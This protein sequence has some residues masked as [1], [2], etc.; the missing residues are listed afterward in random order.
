MTWAA[1]C[2]SAPIPA[3]SQADTLAYKAYGKTLHFGDGTATATNSTTIYKDDLRRK[4]MVFSGI[5]KNE[6]S[7]KSPKSKTIPGCWVCQFHPEFKSK[8]LRSPSPFSRLYC[9][10]DPCKGNQRRSRRRPPM[11]RGVHCRRAQ[12]DKQM[13]RFAIALSLFFQQS[14]LDG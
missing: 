7:A 6:P 14:Q 2:A 8:P 9:S 10:F 4:G 3:K 5:L 12:G 11:S 1:R 13:R